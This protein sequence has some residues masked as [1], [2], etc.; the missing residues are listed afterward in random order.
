LAVPKGTPFGTVNPGRNREALGRKRRKRS[1]EK[2]RKST[3]KG[4]EIPTAGNEPGSQEVVYRTPVRWN[5]RPLFT[6]EGNW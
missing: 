3:Q 1:K 2:Q 6:T 5:L 4:A